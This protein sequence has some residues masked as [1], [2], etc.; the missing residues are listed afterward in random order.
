MV[1]AEVW[2]LPQVE[3]EIDT[4]HPSARSGGH[5]RS[6]RSGHAIGSQA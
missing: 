2:A 5:G 4:A 6:R 1:K 3:A